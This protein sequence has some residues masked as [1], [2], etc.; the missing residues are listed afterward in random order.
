MP[1]KVSSVVPLNAGKVNRVLFDVRSWKKTN[2]SPVLPDYHV[3]A[4]PE[5]ADIAKH[6]AHSS[7]F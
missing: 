2:I 1:R 7:L 4:E 3:E 5:K 6:E